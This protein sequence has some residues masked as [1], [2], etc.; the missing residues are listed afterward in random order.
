M[1]YKILNGLWVTGLI[2]VTCLS[3]FS[4]LKAESQNDKQWNSAIANKSCIIV[5]GSTGKFEKKRIKIVDINFHV[6]LNLEKAVPLPNTQ[7]KMSRSPLALP[8][9]L[10]IVR[11][12]TILRILQNPSG[13]KKTLNIS[14]SKI[15]FTTML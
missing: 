1:R 8:L 12:F 7:G 5:V 2:S 14:P 11:F 9:R 3:K 10:D 4:Y 6:H 15:G 13:A